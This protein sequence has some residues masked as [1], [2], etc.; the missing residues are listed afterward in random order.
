MGGTA[1][2]TAGLATAAKN[3]EGGCLFCDAQ[4]GPSRKIN[5]VNHMDPEENLPS[6][7]K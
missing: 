1:A 5:R 2:K 4:D 3:N 6:R 7:K